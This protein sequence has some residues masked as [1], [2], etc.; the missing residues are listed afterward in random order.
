MT[1]K[2]RLL[3]TDVHVQKNYQEAMIDPKQ[4]LLKARTG[5]KII[6]MVFDFVF[7]EF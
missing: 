3:G 2:L 7:C 6:Q 1:W 5:Q 4:I